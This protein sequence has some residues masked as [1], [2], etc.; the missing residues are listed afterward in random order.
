M[1]PRKTTTTRRRS[2]ITTAAGSP[3]FFSWHCCVQ[4]EPAA[5]QLQTTTYPFSCLSGKAT[6]PRPKSSRCGAPWSKI[7]TKALPQPKLLP[8]RS[9]PVSVVVRFGCY[10]QLL[11]RERRMRMEMGEGAVTKWHCFHSFV[12]RCRRRML[13]RHFQ[14]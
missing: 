9:P 1:Q 2:H 4:R 14:K 11:G 13:L 10:A 6:R 3:T 5:G 8:I 12:R 7:A